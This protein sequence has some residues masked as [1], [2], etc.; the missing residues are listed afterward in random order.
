MR[1]ITKVFVLTLFLVFLVPK[2]VFAEDYIT[3]AV[4]AL[5]KSPVFVYP[6]TEGTDSTTEAKL[7]ARLNN[8]DNIVLV[9]LPMDGL[10]G[11]D[12]DTIVKSLSNG[13]HD[14]RIIGLAVG[15]QVVGYAPTLPP[16]VAEDQMN[17]ADTMATD[18]ITALG[19]FT[20]NIHEWQKANP[21]PSPTPKPTP[22]HTPKPTPTPRPPLTPTQLRQRVQ[23]LRLLWGISF[24]I[25]LSALV[26]VLIR[27]KALSPRQHTLRTIKA[28][29]EKVQTQVGLIGN[30][31]LRDDLLNACLIGM[32][33]VTLFQKAK[34]HRGYAEEKFP[35]YVQNMASQVNALLGHESGMYPRQPE[36]LKILMEVLLNYD[37]LFTKLQ[38]GNPDEI[39]LMASI[40]DSKAA[41]ITNLGYLPEELNQK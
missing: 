18:P 29:I 35:V 2:T 28:S 22:T 24:G 27:T 36:D 15:D 31:R 38:E 7:R 16:L 21:Q 10:K 9:M 11:T 5:K 8:N 13:L 32:G 20:W 26:V 1:N 4:E 33:V 41:M 25:F 17:R 40:M 34:N 30:S 23:L 19:T 39:R 14:E 37:S 3:S 12:I 6:G